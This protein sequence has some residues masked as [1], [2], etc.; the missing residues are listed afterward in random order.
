[1]TRLRPAVLFVAPAAS[2]GARRRPCGAAAAAEA[3]RRRRARRRPAARADVLRRQEGR[4][5]Q[6]RPDARRSTRGRR[7]RA[8]RPGQRQL[9]GPFQSQGEGQ[10]PKF[11]LDAVLEGD[12]PEPHGG[13]HV[14]RRQGLRPLP[15]HGLRRSPTRSS[16]SSRPATSRRR[17]SGSKSRASRFAALGLDPRSWLTDPQER[18]RG[19]G[20]RR[21]HDQDHRRRRLPTL[22]DD[23]NGR[24]ARRGRSACRARRGP[25]Q[26][27][28]RAAP[29][30]RARRS[31]TRRSR[32]TPAR[33]TRS[34]AGMRVDLGVRTPAS[35]QRSGTI[36]LRPPLTD[37]NEDQDIAEPPTPSR[38]TSCS[39]S[40]AACGLGARR[41]G[42]AAPA[43]AAPAAPAPAAAARPR[44]S[45]STRS[46]STEAGSDV[47]EGAASAPTCCA[48]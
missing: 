29:A 23:V 44:T 6:A 40:S 18:R 12:G 47:D 37:L 22:L 7:R 9:S 30:G 36:A 4:V 11:D 25:Q 38:S 27:T 1:M 8:G 19:E 13:R 32:S 31:R 16:S 14:D 48:P 42:S 28:R 39:A 5:G 26:L 10:L 35:R 46:A 15:G 3:R 17:S 20:R 21:R 43:R 33:T 24:C 45:R 41:R 34:C 2:L